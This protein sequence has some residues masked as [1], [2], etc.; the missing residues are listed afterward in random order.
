MRA[1]INTSLEFSG[2]NQGL[3]SRSGG[4]P[5]LQPWIANAFD[6]S[7]E[8]YFAE[9]GYVGLAY[10]YK[11]LRSYVYSQQTPFD[12][13]GLPIPTGYNG[14]TPRPIG[15]YTRPANGEGGNLKG[16]EFTLSVPFDIFTPAL[17]GFGVQANHSD[18]SSGIKRQGPDGPDEPIAG[19]SD[20]VT[21]ISLY[22]E[23]FGFQARVGMRKRS[24]FLGEIQGFGADRSFVY[25]DGE[26]VG[27]VQVGY[28]FQ[29]G[30]SFEGLSILLQVNNVT[31]E[32]YRQ[33]FNGNGLTQR[34]EEYGRQYLLGATYKF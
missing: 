10:F 24:D 2:V 22:Y 1:S 19:L 27:D 32:P 5:Q 25:I 26:T 3:W 33:F 16:W 14:P 11:D 31:D 18:T 7:W 30:S 34:Y 15:V 13:S 4:N 6:L 9:R 23:N 29:E 28:A 21:N 17:E 8:K 12:A 20:R